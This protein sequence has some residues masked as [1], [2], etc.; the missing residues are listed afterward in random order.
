MPSYPIL[1][2][3]RLDCNTFPRSGPQ[4]YRVCSFSG[5]SVAKP[6][7]A[8]YLFHTAPEAKEMHFRQTVDCRNALLRGFLERN[9]RLSAVTSALLILVL[10]APHMCASP[11]CNETPKEQQSATV[12]SCSGCC[13]TVPV[14]A[15][16]QPAAPGHKECENDCCERPATQPGRTELPK[17]ELSA[18]DLLPWVCP[19]VQSARAVTL[20][21]YA[22]PPPEPPL[23]LQLCSFLI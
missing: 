18:I 10:L 17:T 5:I 11:C 19:F 12:S 16:S 14:E 8:V 21:P 4:G 3:F 7:E 9:M 23:N 2:R 15:P 20:V 1:N 13:A 22:S 6:E